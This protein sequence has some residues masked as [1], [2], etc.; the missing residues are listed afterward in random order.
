MKRCSVWLGT[1]ALVVGVASAGDTPS[2]ETLLGE[3]VETYTAAL[4]TEARDARLAA[5]RRAKHLFAA[6][7]EQRREAAPALYTNLGNAALLSRD[8]G[9]AVLAYRRALAVAPDSAQARQNLEH[10]RSLVPDWVPTPQ[11]SGLWN[12]LIR[13]EPASQSARFR[14]GA[15]FCAAAAL[16][17]AAGIRWRRSSL[18]QAALY[19]ALVWLLLVGSAV[20]GHQHAR[21]RAAVVTVDETLARSADSQLAPSAFPEPLPG[22]TEVGIVDTRPPWARV[23]LANGDDVWVAESS[24]T[25]IERPPPQGS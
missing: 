5:F 20:L 3:A 18:R 19:P 4:G 14:L 13:P 9:G 1:W 10:A 2:S 12:H 6:V 7:A 24:L 8:L 25:E 22:G 21:L 16:L 15:L 11:P 17:R 23:R